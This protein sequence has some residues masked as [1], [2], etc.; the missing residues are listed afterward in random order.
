[1]PNLPTTVLVAWAPSI[2]GVAAPLTEVL[3]PTVDTLSVVPAPLE[4]GI[5]SIGETRSA[6]QRHGIRTSMLLPHPPV[7]SV[8]SPGASRW[9]R[10][11][12]AGLALRLDAR[13]VARPYAAVLA[14]TDDLRQGPFVL[15]LPARFLH[16]VDRL[17]L[18]ARPGGLRLQADVAAVALPAA[19][20]LL[21]PVAD[22]W[23]ALS[24]TDPIATELWA[25]S[26]AERWL[27]RDIEMQGPWE[28]PSVQRATELELGVRIPSDMTIRAASDAPLPSVARELLEET[29][30]RLGMQVPDT[31]G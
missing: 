14:L 6:W 1:M 7:W 22:G 3:P 27:G 10:I 12:A 2:V 8:L 30:S 28:D 13:I 15:D 19:S 23:L 20:I 17:R 11:D 21:T 5:S 24:G 9:N 26:L 18:A 16:P 4:R 25:L 29:A 31:I